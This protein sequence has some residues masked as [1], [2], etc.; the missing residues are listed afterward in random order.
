MEWVNRKNTLIMAWQINAR[1]TSALQ[2]HATK[3][4]NACCRVSPE[5]VY[6]CIWR[7]IMKRHTS[8]HHQPVLP[9]PPICPFAPARKSVRIYIYIYK[10]IY[11]YIC[12]FKLSEQ[13]A[14]AIDHL[15]FQKLYVHIGVFVHCRVYARLRPVYRNQLTGGF[16]PA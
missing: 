7:P 13:T 12:S 14:W 2:T 9:T 6:Q 4:R 16:G 1:R 5:A 8:H 11:I 10:I 15:L 3:L